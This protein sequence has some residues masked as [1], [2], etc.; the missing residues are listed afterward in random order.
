MASNW[1]SGNSV[2]AAPLLDTRV[3]LSGSVTISRVYGIDV[4]EL[5]HW[6]ANEG[7]ESES[8][9][10]F[11]VRISW[12]DFKWKVKTHQ[13]FHHFCSFGFEF[14]FYSIEIAIQAID[15]FGWKPF[16]I[17]TN[18]E[19]WSGILDHNPFQSCLRHWHRR[20]GSQLIKSLKK[21]LDI[22]ILLVKS[23]IIFKIE[24]FVKNTVQ[25][26]I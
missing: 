5:S 4:V 18:F 3:E 26:K 2:F 6:D 21:C 15:D 13:K 23:F 25:T 20:T 19:D 12:E 9:L 11:K 24:W 16:P 8:H 17:Y 22:R 14:E 1:I 10:K 7:Q